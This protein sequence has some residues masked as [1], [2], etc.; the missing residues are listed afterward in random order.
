MM[1]HIATS[2]PI[3]E[4]RSTSSGFIL[5]LKYTCTITMNGKHPPSAN[6]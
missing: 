3:W 1:V 4:R 2:I 5:M 6:A